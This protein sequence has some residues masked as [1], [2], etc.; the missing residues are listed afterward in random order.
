MVQVQKLGTGVQ[1]KRY[2]MN[3]KGKRKQ[4]SNTLPPAYIKCTAQLDKSRQNYIR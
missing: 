3:K 4:T 1:K 2:M